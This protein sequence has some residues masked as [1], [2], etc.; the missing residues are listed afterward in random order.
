VPP[1][2]GPRQTERPR[3][4][5][6][7]WLKP[8]YGALLTRL[9]GVPGLTLGATLA[10]CAAGV[11]VLPA[12]GGRFLPEL[13]EGHYIVHTASLP[14]TSLTET[15]RL[16]T[17][18]QAAFREVPGVV[19]VSQFA[20]RAERSADTFGSHYAEYEVDL[21]PLSGADQQRVLEALR[22]ILDGFPG[23]RYEVNTFLTERVDETVSG[24][25]SPVVVNLYGKELHA[26]DAR[27][28][29]VA[30]VM[31]DIPGATDVQV[32]SPTGMPALHVRLKLAE[33]AAW[34]MQPLQVTQAL[35][36]AVEGR[37]VGR[38]FEGD[39][40]F[41]I[42]VIMDR[43]ARD[44]PEDIGHLPL[45]TPDGTVITL[46]QVATVTQDRRPLQHPASQTPQRLQNRDLQREPRRH[47]RLHERVAPARGEQ[48]RFDADSYPEFSPLGG[49]TGRRPRG[50]I[51][52]SLFAGF[53]VLLLSMCHRQRPAAGHHLLNLPFSLLGGVAWR[54]MARRRG[55]VGGVARGLRHPV[56]ASPVRKLHH[57]GVPLPP[58]DRDRRPALEPRHRPARRPGAPALHPHD[59]PGDRAGHAA[60][61]HRQRQPGP[62]NHGSH[63]RHHHRRAGHLHAAEPAD[64]AHGAVAL[65]AVRRTPRLVFRKS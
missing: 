57:A 34:G 59:R 19:S 28:E 63:G 38:V 44:D 5:A 10:V 22:D 3:T 4:P 23:I 31:R 35:Q 16:G 25:T 32:R 6:I 61:R 37:V 48:V 42:S 1:A 49:G 17:A 14:G 40:P 46:D 27:A 26:L 20:G 53:G 39:R 62:R 43:E 41:E 11:L 64:P 33:L 47:R 36:T 56:P 12:L 52:H 2:A 50:L 45:R 65:G 58:P 18:L 60:H 24:Y 21:K 8:R 29:E 15:L 51:L 9:S 55:P 7:R 13:R 30:A 54:H